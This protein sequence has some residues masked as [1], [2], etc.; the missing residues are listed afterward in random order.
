MAE[1]D[2][3]ARWDYPQEWVDQV[4]KPL[5]R[6]VAR[7]SGGILAY[8]DVLQETLLILALRGEEAKREWEK[9][10]NRYLA[11]WLRQRVSDATKTEVARAQRNVHVQ[12]TEDG[13][14][15]VL[16]DNSPRL[17]EEDGIDYPV[18][19]TKA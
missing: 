18:E 4:A 1:C 3:E 15:L 11:A 2:S 17:R 8:Q 13:E 16:P 10:G 9:G 5:S 14:P 6:A 7:R 19:V 12:W